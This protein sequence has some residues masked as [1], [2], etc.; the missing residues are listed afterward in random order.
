[1]IYMYGFDTGIIMTLKE[2]SK[3]FN[4]L[5]ERI[6]KID[7]KGLRKLRYPSTRKKLKEYYQ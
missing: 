4:L 3:K 6:R 2:L 7:V 1:M 5:S